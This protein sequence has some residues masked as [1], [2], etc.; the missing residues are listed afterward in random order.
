[1]HVDMGS[2]DPS[3]ARGNFIYSYELDKTLIKLISAFYDSLISELC[4]AQLSPS[5]FFY[6]T[7]G[8]YFPQMINCSPGHPVYCIS[9]Y[10]F[11]SAAST[12]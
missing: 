4:L 1:M 7:K 3:G 11:Y 10:A 5:L 9:K 8:F 6:R 12:S 2:K